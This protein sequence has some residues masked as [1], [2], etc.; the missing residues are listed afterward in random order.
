ML[1]ELHKIAEDVRYRK[2]MKWTVCV[3]ED[4]PYD[5]NQLYKNIDTAMYQW[6][7]E[8]AVGAINKER[9]V[10]QLHNICLLKQ[11]LD[12]PPWSAPPTHNITTSNWFIYDFQFYLMLSA[13]LIKAC[14]LFEGFCDDAMYPSTLSLI[15]WLN[16]SQRKQD[17]LI[18]TI[19][20][21]NKWVYTISNYQQQ[22]KYIGSLNQLEKSFLL[23]PGSFKL[24][25]YLKHMYNELNKPMCHR[26][27]ENYQHRIILKIISQIKNQDDYNNWQN[28]RTTLSLG[29]L[30]SYLSNI[31]SDEFFYLNSESSQPFIN[32]AELIEE[33]NFWQSISNTALEII[34]DSIPFKPE[35]IFTMRRIIQS[36]Q[37]RRTNHFHQSIAPDH[38]L[39]WIHHPHDFVKLLQP[40]IAK[41]YIQLKGTNDLE[42]IVNYLLKFIHVRKKNNNGVLAPK[43]ILSYF[44]KANCGDL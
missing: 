26:E 44:K 38:T 37:Q 12:M 18:Q 29:I 21:G 32:E 25:P 17:A 36:L 13:L 27:A 30:T 10:N 19:D 8:L 33:T 31:T 22:S 43:S 40:A 4:V 2:N 3:C 9:I 1:S 39:E 14:T 41:G 35:I 23:L 15:P 6:L 5:I 20:N 16:M 42:P 28:I 24:Y 11:S 34:P 7:D